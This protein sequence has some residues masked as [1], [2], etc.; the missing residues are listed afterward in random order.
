MQNGGTPAHLEET[1]KRT[2]AIAKLGEYYASVLGL[3][4]SKLA[5]NM[6]TQALNVP[7]WC[8]FRK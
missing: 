1:T 7:D 5:S 2:E 3:R 8:D 4:D 6:L